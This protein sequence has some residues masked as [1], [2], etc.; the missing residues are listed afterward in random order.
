MSQTKKSIAQTFVPPSDYE[1]DFYARQAINEVFE[2][3]G[4]VVSIEDKKKSL[5]KFGENLLVDTGEATVMTLPAGVVAET[6]ATTNAITHLSSSNAGDTQ[7][8]TIEGHTVADGVFTFVTQTK[9]L[10]GQTKVA[11]DTPLARIT[12]ME[13]GGTTNNAGVIYGFEDDTLSSG[14]PTTAAKVHIMVPVGENQTL[15]ASTTISN[16]DYCFLT[17]FYASINKKTAGFAIVRLRVRT[18]GGVFRTVF[19]RGI[20]SA[21]TD[22]QM[23]LRPYIIVPKNAD[24][25]VTAEADAASTFVV[26]GFNSILASVVT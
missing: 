3:Y 8:W 12:R 20:Q 4:D 24:I 21:G 5:H 10:T 25:I 26:G 15:K 7:T 19:K 2:T 9:A 22:L 16:T 14:V 13:N 6:Y 1:V 17:S 23:E 18:A 11:L